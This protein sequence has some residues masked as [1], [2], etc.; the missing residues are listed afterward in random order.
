MKSVL[1]PL[2][3]SSGNLHLDGAIRCPWSFHSVLTDEND[4]VEVRARGLV[5][6]DQI[7]K[8]MTAAPGGY[9]PLQA[10]RQAFQDALSYAGVEVAH[11]E[12]V[13]FPPAHDC[14]AMIDAAQLAGDA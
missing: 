1:R 8:L 2:A 14:T 5:Q 6:G 9:L 7:A 13:V 12:V 10:I 4:R 11:M 3:A